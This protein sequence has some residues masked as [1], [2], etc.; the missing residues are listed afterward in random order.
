[1]QKAGCTLDV[2]LYL[3]LKQPDEIG[4]NNFTIFQ[5]RILKL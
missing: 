5:V 1:M 4:N 3:I 2:V